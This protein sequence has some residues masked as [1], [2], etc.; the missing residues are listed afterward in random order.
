MQL[1]KLWNLA[2]PELGTD[3]TIKHFFFKHLKYADQVM[4]GRLAT[5]QN[6][7]WK[8]E[9]SRIHCPLFSE[10]VKNA[11]SLTQAKQFWPNIF[12][13]VAKS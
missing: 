8:A 13:D 3:Q 6:I 9:I 5:S 2:N 1:K 11:I 4:F 7:A 12:H 10:K